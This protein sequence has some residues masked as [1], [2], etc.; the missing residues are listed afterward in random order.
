[1]FQCCPKWSVSVEHW[2]HPS[3]AAVWR[4]DCFWI[5]MLLLHEEK[6]CS[7]HSPNFPF[8]TISLCE[9]VNFDIVHEEEEEGAAVMVASKSRLWWTKE[10]RKEDDMN[11]VVNRR[12][13]TDLNMQTWALGCSMNKFFVFLN[14]SKSCLGQAHHSHSCLKLEHACAPAHNVHN[15]KCKTNN[16]EKNEWRR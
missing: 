12:N 6:I 13:A 10:R 5:L 7:S 15:W 4:T 14:K 2:F 3:L 16:K 8:S 9:S 1:M 11:V